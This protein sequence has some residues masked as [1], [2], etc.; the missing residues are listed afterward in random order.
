MAKR[1]VV[2]VVKLHVGAG[3]ASPAA[4]ARDLGPH[5]IN[6]LQFCQAYNAATAAQRGLVV[7]VHVTVY[8]DRSFTLAT[9]TPTT[10][11]MLRAAAGVARGSDRANGSPSAW[12]TRAQLR[13]IARAKLPDLNTPDLDGA[14]RMVAGTARS[15]GIG[16]R[17]E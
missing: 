9:R 13:E 14:A 7:P 12:I 2:K 17:D 10:A 8:D 16:I 11:G 6:I 3:E 4:V 1:K 5:G 15:M